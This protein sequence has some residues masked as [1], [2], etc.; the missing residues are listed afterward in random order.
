MKTSS[1]LGKK[2][3]FDLY[4]FENNILKLYHEGLSREVV[5][6]EYKH[7]L[8]ISKVFDKV[9][10]PLELTE[11]DNQF[12]IIYPRLKGKTILRLLENDPTKLEEYAIL[13]TRFHEKM[14]NVVPD[15]LK[16]QAEYY[17][18]EIDKADLDDALK[19]DLYEL[20][21]S[22]PLGFQCC[23]GDYQ[24]D[25]VILHD[26]DYSI[27]DFHHAYLGHPTGDIAKTILILQSPRHPADATDFFIKQLKKSR[28]KFIEVYKEYL[29]FELVEFKKFY[30]LAAVTRLNLNLD[31][32]KEWL[33]KI[34]K[35]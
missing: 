11:V 8:E 35:G 24:P 21:K 20:V 33:M 14:L 29:T 12:G 32:E 13:F 22:L 5:E 10:K 18:S 23:H 25:S 16:T 31:M 28:K 30:R 34:I 19:D 17:T 6:K 1:V 15:N 26:N 7:T 3:L 2:S 4:D 9:L 27:A